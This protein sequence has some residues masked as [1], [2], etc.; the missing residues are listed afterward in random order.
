MSSVDVNDIPQVIARAVDLTARR[1][2]ASALTIFDAVY[3]NVPPDKFPQGLSAYGL[4]LSQVQ[5]KNRKGAELC[6]QA[7]AMQPV[8]T[9]HWANLV[10]LYAGAKMARKAAE[11]LDD[12][13]KKHP[14][15]AKLLK[16]ATELGLSRTQPGSTLR[17]A[18]SA[19]ETYGRPALYVVAGLLVA[20]I[21]ASIVW[22]LM[23]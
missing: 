14:K 19:L 5:H 7:I 6:E 4:C 12:A 21:A 16:V 20:G 3:A 2:Y 18:K 11:T 10:R 23:Q 1:D 9:S 17:G 13:L 8:E 15:D 22:L